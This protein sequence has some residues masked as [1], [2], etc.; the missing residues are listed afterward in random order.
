MGAFKICHIMLYSILNPPLTY[1]LTWNKVWS[2]ESRHLLPFWVQLL[3][4]SLL[5][6]PVHPSWPLLQFFKMLMAQC[7]CTHCLHSLKIIYPEICLVPSGHLN[8]CSEV[9]LSK[10]SS[11]ISLPKVEFLLLPSPF[12]PCLIL[13]H[14]PDIYLLCT[15]LLSTK[16]SDL[17]E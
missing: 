9:T 17:W 11:L 15:Y 1:Q 13:A 12:L 5:L 16:V 14:R 10:T 6:I 4:H 3:S 8:I 2:Y 7:L